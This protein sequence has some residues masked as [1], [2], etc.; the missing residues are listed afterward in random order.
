MAM[1][2]QDCRVGCP[3]TVPVMRATFQLVGFNITWVFSLVA[4]ISG[5]GV[6]FAHTQSSFMKSCSGTSSIYRLCTMKDKNYLFI[7]LNAGRIQ[8]EVVCY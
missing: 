5:G 6:L 8:Y 4:G 1:N 7:H 3:R 2:V